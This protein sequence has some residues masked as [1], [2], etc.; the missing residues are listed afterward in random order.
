MTHTHSADRSVGVQESGGGVVGG[1]QG[2]AQAADGGFVSGAMAAQGARV[3]QA[4]PGAAPQV[5]SDL[6]EFTWGK[7]T[8]GKAHDRQAPTGTQ[9]AAA[10]G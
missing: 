3:E 10:M 7:G 6:H 8:A 4:T 9:R 2:G 5:R 1:S